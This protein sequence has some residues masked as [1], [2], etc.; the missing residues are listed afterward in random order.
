MSSPDRDKMIE[1]LKEI[2]KVEQ[3]KI[4]DRC[5]ECGIELWRNGNC[6]Y[7]PTCGEGRCGG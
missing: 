7:C 6:G 4:T 5:P 1:T 2:S 3:P